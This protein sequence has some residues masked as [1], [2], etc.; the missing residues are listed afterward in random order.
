MKGLSEN[1][2]SKDEAYDYLRNA[3]YANRGDVEISYDKETNGDVA[4]FDFNVDIDGK[5]FVA[6]VSKRGGLLITLSGYAESGDAI[7]GKE[8]A[9]E[10]AKNFANNIGFENMDYVWLEIHEN[11]AYINLA[12]FQGDV[13][14]YPDLIKVKVDL[15]S[16]EVI[17]F[18]ALNYAL[19]HVERDVDF[20]I[21]QSEAENLLG[22]DLQMYF[23]QFLI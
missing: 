22:F 1:E 3:V 7:I 18:E 6:Q 13:I 5:H 21:S 15:T 11:V 12:S 4:T 17:G 9:L 19:N 23:Y 20:T 8:Q 14:L 16:Q 10:L 2:V